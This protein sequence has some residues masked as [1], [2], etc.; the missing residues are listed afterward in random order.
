M[1]FALTLLAVALPGFVRVGRWHLPVYALFAAVGLVAALGL[2]QRTAK[3]VGMDADKLW[4][5]GMFGVVAAFVASR[6][7]LVVVEWK[8]FVQYPLLVL[9]APS[10]TYGGIALTVVAVWIYLRWKKLP[11]LAVVDAWA[12]CAAVLAVVLS[13]GHFF[14]GTDAGMPTR[15]PWGVVTAGDTVLGKT[16][17]VQLYAMVAALGMVEFL[18]IRL[19]RRRFVGEVAGMALVVG[20]VISFLLDMVRQPVET[21]GGGWLEASQ[22]VE[23]GSVVVGVGI[24]LFSESFLKWR[25]D[26]DE[27]YRQ[28]IRQLSPKEVAKL[29][30]DYVAGR[31][32][33]YIHEEI[34]FVHSDDP[35]VIE[36]KERF[37]NLHQVPSPG[38][39]T[40]EESDR[41]L[42]DY[43]RRLRIVEETTEMARVD[44]QASLSG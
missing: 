39:P 37:P 7:L 6:V 35:L 4:D 22:W 14:E 33:P 40:R 20:G 8:S 9:A 13:L 3:L 29:I 27:R 25:R 38:V 10:L 23:L 43:A 21:F 11:V 18:L 1:G 12:P 42:L 31:G 41:I 28:A 32:G 2:S 24:L 26:A 30:D 5:A 44:R 36:L 19:K 15:L 16:H 17:P 34:E